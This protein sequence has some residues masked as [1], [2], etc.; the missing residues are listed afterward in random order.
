MGET[1]GDEETRPP[2]LRASVDRLW[3]PAAPRLRKT[4]SAQRPL[5]AGSATAG[6]ASSSATDA[7]P[8]S[9]MRSP[10]VIPPAPRRWRRA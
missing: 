8:S 3:H 4:S 9:T 7:A 6:S 2:A 10:S 1:M 5:A